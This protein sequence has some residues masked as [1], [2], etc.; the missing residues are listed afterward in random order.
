MNRV[1]YLLCARKKLRIILP[2]V[3]KKNKQTNKTL[4]SH[5]YR[6]STPKSQ[7]TWELSLPF[8]I[9]IPQAALYPCL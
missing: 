3:A 7:P 1:S 9:P 2:N 5:T 6:L 8:F 4:D